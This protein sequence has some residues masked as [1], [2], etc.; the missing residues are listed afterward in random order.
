MRKCEELMIHLINT[1]QS[2]MA[3]SN[4]L[5]AYQDNYNFSAVYLH[6][7]RIMEIHF[8]REQLRHMY[9]NCCGWDTV[10]TRSRINAALRTYAGEGIECKAGRRFFRGEEFGPSQSVYV[11]LE[12]RHD[13]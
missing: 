6:G 11:E 1:K 13:K 12:M 7:N 8:Y 9:F 5:V 4:T 2:K 3:G 10:T